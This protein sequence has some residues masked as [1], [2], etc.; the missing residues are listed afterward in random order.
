M[1]R[2]RPFSYFEPK[3]LAEAV[4][5]LAEQGPSAR[6]LAGGTDLLVR[7]KTGLFKPGALVNLKRIPG[8]GQIEPGQAGL[9]IGALAKV[10]ALER[11]PAVKASYP[12]LAQAAGLLGAPP[13]RALA[14]VGGNI[15]RA[16][17]ASDLAPALIVLNAKALVSGPAGER[18]IPVAQVMAGPGAT[19]LA[20]AEVIT[21]FALP[22]PLPHTGAAYL[23]LGRR[24]GM[25]CALVGAAAWLRLAE[26]GS[27]AVEAR[28]VLSSVGPTPWRAAQAE[29]AVLSG[30]LN[31]GLLDEAARLAAQEIKPMSDMRASEAFRRQAASALT[32]RALMAAWEM[33]RKV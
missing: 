21:S 19:S 25:D 16:S 1:N 10:S 22:A 28:I 6:P 24:E 4:Q 7:M 20:P 26:G 14:T 11:S 33:A 31:D 18:R 17:P 2:L 3:S 23:K 27:R 30:T 5:I 12:V 13:V 32:Q 9:H 15:G 29:Q 8:L